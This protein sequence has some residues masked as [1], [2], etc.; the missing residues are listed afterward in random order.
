MNLNLGSVGGFLPTIIKGFGKF[1]S[2]LLQLE[3]TYVLSLGYSNARAQLFTVPPYVVALVFMLILTSFSD[4]RQTRG[5]PA[6][7]VFCLG[8]IGWAILLTLPA[9]EHYSARYFACICIVT[10]GYTNIPLIMSWQS[11]CTANQSQR[12]TSLGMLN[13]VGQC[14]SV[15]AAFL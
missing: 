7:S 12:A 11:A 6:A 15:A 1:S 13:T 5:L 14:L 8:I 2:S 4:W 10:A 9:H 3:N